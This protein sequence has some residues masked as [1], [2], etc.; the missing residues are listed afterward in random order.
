MSC[1]VITRDQL[2][3]A[4]GGCC[5]HY[6]FVPCTIC[7]ISAGV[8]TIGDFGKCLVLPVTTQPSSFEQKQ[9]RK[10]A[11]YCCLSCL[12]C[13][14]DFIIYVL[15]KPSYPSRSQTT[16]VCAERVLRLMIDCTYTQFCLLLLIFATFLSLKGTIN[17]IFRLQSYSLFMTFANILSKKSNFFASFLQLSCILRKKVVSL[18]RIKGKRR[19]AYCEYSLR[20][21]QKVGQGQ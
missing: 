20:C 1:V 5:F 14:P 12:P 17:Y 19:R 9:H 18:Q 4:I 10:Y 6:L 8:T 16:G 15:K 21:P 3:Y 13:L 2:F 11:S 7:I